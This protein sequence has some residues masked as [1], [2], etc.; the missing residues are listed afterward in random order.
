MLWLY[1]CACVC[2]C[3]R[4]RERERDGDCVSVCSAFVCGSKC[5]FFA[6]SHDFS[7]EEVWAEEKQL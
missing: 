4:E 6:T 1:V 5:V 3:V 7:P 2:V